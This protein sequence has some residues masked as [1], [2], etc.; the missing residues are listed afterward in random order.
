[1]L[2]DAKLLCRY[3]ERTL[4]A[5][6]WDPD[7]PI[8]LLVQML[9]PKTGPQATWHSGC[10]KATKPEAVQDIHDHDGETSPGLANSLYT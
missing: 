1:M 2:R 9:Q 6:V 5:L 4:S 8:V 7:V 3:L 10:Y